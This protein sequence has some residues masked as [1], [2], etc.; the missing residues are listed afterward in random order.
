MRCKDDYRGMSKYLTQENIEK[1]KSFFTED[2]FSF[3]RNIGVDLFRWD[4]FGFGE[5]SQSWA[6]ILQFGK[7]SFG[8]TEGKLCSMLL[9]EDYAGEAYTYTDE[10]NA[11][12]VLKKIEMCLKIDESKRC[13]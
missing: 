11:G 7:T 10:D 6:N 5:N 9:D 4:E 8:D 1:C 12:E 13:S 2:I 3:S